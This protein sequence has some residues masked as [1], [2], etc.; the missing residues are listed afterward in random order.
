MIELTV[1]TLDSQNHSFSVEDDIT[2]AQFKEK[3]AEKINIPADTQRIIYCGRVLKDE[4]KLSEYDVNGKVVHLV[5]RAPPTSGQGPTRTAS[6]QPQRRNVRGLEHGMYVGSMAFP[7]NLMESQG[8]VPPPPTHSLAAS[9]LNVA[10]RMFRRAEAVLNLLENPQLRGNEQ[11]PSEEPQEE[12]TPVL[13]ARVI[14]PTNPMDDIMAAVESSF[15]F[16][17]P[18]NVTNQGSGFARN[19]GTDSTSQNSIDI[20]TPP[21]H[22]ASSTP[23]GASPIS[24]STENLAAEVAEAANIEGSG[25]G[26]SGAV[27]RTSGDQGA[28]ERGAGSSTTNSGNG[29]AENASRT[30]EMA[31]LLETLSRLQLRLAPFLEQYQ[32]FMR[33][34]PTIAT[35]DV[36]KTQVTINRVSE[37][38]H[39]LGHAY[40]S[41]SDIIVRVRTPPP[42]PLL[43]RPI[44][45]QH[46]AVVQ[47]GFPIQ[48]E[49]QINISQDVPPPNNSGNV[50]NSTSNTSVSTNTTATPSSTSPPTN[51][52]QLP[53]H[54]MGGAPLHIEPRMMEF[55]FLPGSLRVQS[56]PFEIRDIR[57]FQPVPT[58]PAQAP[59]TPAVPGGSNGTPSTAA[60]TSNSNTNA[61]TTG[62]SSTSTASGQ[63]NGASMPGSQFNNPNFD[64]YMEVTPESITIDSLE[65]TLLRSNQAGDMFRGALN[66]SPPE[67]LQSIMQMAGQLIN[68][69][70][71]QPTNNNSAPPTTAS[72]TTPPSSSA[73]PATTTTPESS[74]QT[75]NNQNATTS[76]VNAQPPQTGQ[77]SQAR[78]NTQTNPTTATHTRS[79][80]RP[81]VHLAQHALQGGFDPFLP[82]NSHHVPTRRPRMQARNVVAMGGNQNNNT[83]AE[84]GPQMGPGIQ[85]LPQLNPNQLSPIYNIV[86]GIVNSF[87]TA[88]RQQH[89]PPQTSQQSAPQQSAAANNANGGNGQQ[90]QGLPEGVPP[91]FAVPFT[92]QLQNMVNN[93][94]DVRAATQR[95]GPTISQ[96]LQQLQPDFDE[97]Y[98]EGE[99]L[100]SDLI[101]L[102]SRNLTVGDMIQLNV[103]HL[104][105]LMR[106]RGNI[107]R[108]F[109]NRVMDGT[110]NTAS[111][112]RAVNRLVN[113]MQP[114]INDLGN[115]QVRNNIDI[116]RSTTMLFRNRLPNIISLTASRNPNSLRLLVEQCKITI[117]QFFALIVYASANGIPGVEDVL[118]N[119]VRRHMHG[120]SRDL[121]MWIRD[122]LRRSIANLDIPESVLQPY[123][124]RQIDS[125]PT[126]G[127]GNN[128]NSV[129]EAMDLDV[130]EASG[131]STDLA[132][133]AINLQEDGEPLPPVDIGSEAWHDQVPAEWVPIIVRD[134]QRQR[135][136]NPQPAFSDAYLSGMPSKRRKIVTSAK[137][138]GSLPQVIQESV[139][140]AVTS[141]SLESVAPIDVVSQAAAADINI[142]SAYREL[143]R[144]SVQSTLQ[145]NEDF[146]PERYPNASNYFNKPQ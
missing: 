85:G 61:T 97:T 141:S 46:S 64:F 15:A 2:V 11:P 42:R 7:T 4:I 34:D 79:T 70:N 93:L 107:R 65:T 129:E 102:F 126:T 87:R 115:L 94:S 16:T 33:N 127:L 86:Q 76:S 123:I 29:L 66:T 121:E 18:V 10:K 50:Q 88:Y 122:K 25:E 145:N 41:L 120:M 130:H 108:F 26:S 106:I 36:R 58:N 142:Q 32:N 72:T 140:R 110:A 14:V 136:Q 77:N 92:P 98:V 30:T 138:Q 55:P 82:C 74:T 124:V 19:E 99:S 139:R 47:T 118:Q 90:G 39:F 43:C 146:T 143:L 113:E 8:I 116:V 12:V 63:Q 69:S 40:H 60:A 135:R 101:V 57:G 37:V 91:L 35:E 105:P 119:M 3:I 109:L 144:T 62:T 24:T 44:L 96:I 125:L 49:A 13:E 133:N 27:P 20:D 21:M 73:S 80:A 134:T 53:E 68:R 132:T 114:F 112:D 78:G 23:D 128:I 6:P 48:V 54:N 67:F 137:P 84:G 103:N 131:S 83:R 71:N 28:S 38:L 17:R 1:K 56:F 81:H 75:S 52:G 111:I 51:S 89:R 45:I 22:S 31:D 100:F 117:R 5:Q 59:A 9:R 104:E 95:Q